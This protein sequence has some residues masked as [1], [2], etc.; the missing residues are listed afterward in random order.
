MRSLRTF[1][2]TVVFCLTATGISAQQTMIKLTVNNTS[3]LTATLVDNSSTAALIELLKNKP[4]TIEM[5]DY[6]SME[7]VGSIGTSLPRNDEQ[8][9][10]EPGD[11]ILYQGSAL[12]IYYAPNSWNFTRLGKIN[13]ITQQEL[14]A[15]LGEGD[16]TVKLELADTAT[17]IK[18]K[19]ENE[20][21]FQVYLD[22]EE[23]C[24]NVSGR[25]DRISLLDVNGKSIMTSHDN[26]VNINHVPSGIYFVKI[27]TGQNG[28][29]VKK[30]QKRS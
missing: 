18:H 2:L 28:T 29:V 20:D 3:E 6:G 22:Q 11:I 19:D 8:I 16:V 26:T 30:I 10:T 27:E 24:L 1:F 21:L 5:H 13:N 14:K 7:K 17:S 15:V 23:N 25:F 4:L 9:T 12:V